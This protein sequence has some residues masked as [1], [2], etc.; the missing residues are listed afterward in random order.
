MSSSPELSPSCRSINQEG[1][2]C[3]RKH[4]HKA[5]QHSNGNGGYWIG[6]SKKPARKTFPKPPKREPLNYR[7]GS[8]YL[9]EADYQ[10]W[11]TGS[12]FH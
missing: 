5:I 12:Y 11:A 1:E 4:G 3:V 7:E 10:S 8:S 6:G 9:S 2:T